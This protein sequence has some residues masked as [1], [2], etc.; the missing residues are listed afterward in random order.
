MFLIFLVLLFS[1][2]ACAL[3]GSFLVLRGMAMLVDAMSHSVLLGIVL[4]YFVFQDL[5][6]PWLFLGAS[7]MSVLTVFC[8]EWLIKTKLLAEDAAM[9]IV[10]PF[11]FSVSVILISRFFKN[12]HL[13]LDSVFTGNILF[14]SLDTFSF[15]DY[16]VPKSL[17]IM[18]ALLCLVLLV[19]KSFYKEWKLLTFD[20][21]YAQVIGLPVLFLHYLLMTLCSFVAVYSFEVIGIVLVLSFMVAPASTA[22]LLTKDLKKML[23]FSVISASVQVV[24]GMVFS[25]LWDLSITGVTAFVGAG[26]FLMAF[27]YKKSKKNKVA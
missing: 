27:L 11:F 20:A 26:L 24:L 19:I 7:L 21:A 16:V 2:C 1:G 17:L 8:I 12:T 6:S 22:F 13:D 5:S 23:F 15:G 18:A 10:F 25:Y 9:G 3:L 4:F 14:S